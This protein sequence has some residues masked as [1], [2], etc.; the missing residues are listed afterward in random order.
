MDTTPIKA[1]SRSDF[2]KGAARKLRSQDRVPATIYRDGKTP[3]HVTMNAHELSLIYQKSNN[4]NLVLAIDVD[5]TTHHAILKEAQKHP[6]SRELLHLDFYQVLEGVKLTVEVPVRTK[7][8]ALGATLGGQIRLLRRTVRTVG[9]PESLPACIE[10]DVSPL[11]IGDF[12]R[13]SALTAP[14]GCEFVIEHDYNILTCY[15]KKSAAK[16]AGDGEGG[17]A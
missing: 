1:E 7:G 15:G 14:E 17:E 8:R 10:V 13:A 4:P 16:A 11:N 5:G 2:G 3:T 9:A 12:I 6:I